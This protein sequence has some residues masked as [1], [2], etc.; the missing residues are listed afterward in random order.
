MS[1][2]CGAQILSDPGIL[3]GEPVFYGT[4]VLVRDVLACLRKGM[5]DEEILAGYPT[6][7]PAALEGFVREWPRSAAE[8]KAIGDTQQNTQNECDPAA[9]RNL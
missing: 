9:G 2:P 3:R 6:L 4:R 8:R 5:T 7:R 1:S